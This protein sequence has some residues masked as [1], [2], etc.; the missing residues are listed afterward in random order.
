MR[1]PEQFECANCSTVGS[2]DEH[3]GCS[4]CHSQAV[5]SLERIQLA[6]IHITVTHGAPPGV[7]N[8]FGHGRVR[9]MPA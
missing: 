7:A 2:L 4:H 8:G 1:H 3:G 5:M 6:A 9:T